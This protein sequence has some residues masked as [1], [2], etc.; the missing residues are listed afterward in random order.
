MENRC[1]MT[2]L[3]ERDKKYIPSFAKIPYA[4]VVFKRG[5]GVWLEDYDGKKYLDFLSSASS[6]NLGHGNRRIAEAVFEQM[7]N[8]VNYTSV[9]FYTEPVSRLA[10]ILSE[11]AP[12][13]W[14]KKVAFGMAGS[15]GIDGMIKMVRAY[16]GKSKIISFVGAYHGSTLG[17]ISLSA[18][19]PN[20]SRKFGPLL[21]DIHH[22][23]YPTC[24]RCPFGH[25]KNSC[26]RECLSQFETAFNSYLPP[27]EVAAIV[28]EP[29]AGDAGLIVPPVHFMKELKRYC[30]IHG[31]L[32]VVDEIQQG[33]GRT[34]KWFGI[35]HFGIE[36]DVIV[37][38][39]SL[40]AGLP[41]SAIIA[42][43]EIMDS[44]GAPAH[45]FTMSGN[46]TVVAAACEQIKIIEEQHLLE[47]AQ[48]VGEYIMGR[49]NG[50]KNQYSFIGDVRGLGLSIGVDL[51]HGRDDHSP[52]CEAT[53]KICSQCIKSGLI[54]IYVG[55][56]TLRIQPPIIIT[57]E[58]AEEG[59]AILE[60][61]FEMYQ[62]GE[63]G[64]DVLESMHGW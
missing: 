24:F 35:E 27:D 47:N 19:S 51:I 61:V 56:S 1:E 29:I 22:F 54:Q 62:N 38:G 53:M 43:S 37:M 33:I 49:L 57:K 18:I 30:E 10:K 42:R 11:L 6:S 28:I 8:I 3:I 64:D 13:A 31:I 5:E 4:D 12:G 58:E 39:K 60:N 21:P 23:Q 59:L 20:M 25:E 48:H 32:F 52:N 26:G 14:P 45:T 41:L 44:M 55:K 9:Y 40:G 2:A 63:I 50:M 34:G 46:A 17:A 36:P 7:S 15:D 16:T